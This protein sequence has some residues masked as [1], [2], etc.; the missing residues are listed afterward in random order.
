M[1]KI[2]AILILTFMI[3]SLLVGCADT[4]AGEKNGNQ[5]DN[6]QSAIDGK[7]EEQDK[8][9]TDI[10]PDAEPENKPEPD[11]EPEPE[12]DPD[13]KVGTAV[14]DLFNDVTLETLN[15][16]T[17]STADYRGKIVIL[18]I[19]AT[20]C[21]PCKTELP[22]FDMIANEYAED[23]VII[24][25]HE[26]YTRSAAPSYVESNFPDSKIIFAYDTPYGDAYYAAGGE[27]Y[28][29]QTVI[30]DQNGVIIYSD[31]GILSHDKLVSIIESAK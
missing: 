14:G 13:L 5:N 1:K 2:I 16:G 23:V 31:S 19:W 25:A 24:A 3:G 6:Q 18:N 27:G 20:R 28:I 12:P 17:V 9:N 4:S 15:G 7:E 21:S 30:M 10:E 22:D 26:D 11:P 8:S 29:P